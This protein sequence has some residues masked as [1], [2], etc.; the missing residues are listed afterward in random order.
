MHIIVYGDKLM[1][2]RQYNHL[3]FHIKFP[4][5]GEKLKEIPT[6]NKL[7]SKKAG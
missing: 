7:V 3:S 1:L 5:I 6:F 4:P 2:V